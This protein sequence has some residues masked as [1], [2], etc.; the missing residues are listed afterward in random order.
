MPKALCITGIVV[1]ILL[2]VVFT[3]DLAVG[4]PF[5]RASL[6]IMDIAAIICSGIL[7]YLS[8]T[9]FRQQT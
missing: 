3:L 1:A 7:A 5:N 9:T 8:W 6:W 2:F 4:I